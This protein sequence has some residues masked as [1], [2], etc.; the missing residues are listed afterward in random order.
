LNWVLK[1]LLRSKDAMSKKRKQTSFKPEDWHNVTPR[2]VVTN[3]QGLIDFL[4]HVFAATGDYRPDAPAIVRIGDSLIMVSDAGIRDAI[5]SFLY[6]YVEDAD[7]TYRRAIGAGAISLEEP[8]E[9]PYGDR[10]GMVKDQWG[11][12]WQIATYRGRQR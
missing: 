2:I 9:M 5:T 6:V 8:S 11:N 1:T 3:A 7:E 4:K 10:R 12:T